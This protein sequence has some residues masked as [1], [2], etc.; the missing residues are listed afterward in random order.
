MESRFLEIGKNAVL[1]ASKKLMEYYSDLS[2]DKI[3]VDEEIEIIIK[4]KILEE[5]PEHSFDGEE[6]GRSGEKNSYI[7]YCDPISSTNNLVRHLP[8]FAVCLTLFENE[9]PKIGIVCDPVCNELYYAEVGNGAYLN[10]K[11]LNVNFKKNFEKLNFICSPKK[12]FQLIQEFLNLKYSYKMFGSWAL[13]FAYVASNKLD[14]CFTNIKD[15]HGTL[16][17]LIIAKEA[18]CYVFDGQNDFWSGSSERILV[19]N[20]EIIVNKHKE[21]IFK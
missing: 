6:T 13:H 21:L 15:I 8:H 9:I 3:E 10:G 5:F 19:A 12:D 17:G 4:N 16:P 1:D 20:S 14:F 18:G 11:K 7:W 2:L